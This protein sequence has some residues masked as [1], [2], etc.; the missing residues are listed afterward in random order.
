M[1]LATVGSESP[2]TVKEWWLMTNMLPVTTG[3]V[4]NP[5]ALFVLMVANDRL[6]HVAPV[7]RSQI[8]SIGGTA[9]GENTERDFSIQN[10]SLPFF[11]RQFRSLQRGQ[12][13]PALVLVLIKAPNKDH[14]S[15]EMAKLRQGGLTVLSIHDSSIILPD[16]IDVPSRRQIHI[17]S[18][19]IAR[20]RK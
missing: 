4:G 10:L 18:T 3:Q 19:G 5:V 6:L 20:I 8:M 13:L 12:V 17:P 15:I 7:V 11:K 2:W 9:T 16:N 14:V 1:P